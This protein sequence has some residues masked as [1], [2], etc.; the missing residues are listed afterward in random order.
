M[1]CVVDVPVSPSQCL[2]YYLAFRTPDIGHWA[3]YCPYWYLVLG[4]SIYS[5]I[6]HLT[7]HIDV[8]RIH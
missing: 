2:H 8:A 1:R 6:V 4:M 7:V 5:L 3:Y